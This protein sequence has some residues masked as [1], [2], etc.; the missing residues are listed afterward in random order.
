MHTC[1][2][3]DTEF[4]ESQAPSVV[5]FSLRGNDNSPENAGAMVEAPQ[6]L[7]PATH[8][9]SICGKN[10][11]NGAVSCCARGGSW[12]GKCGNPGDTRF[13]YTWDEGLRLCEGTSRKSTLVFLSVHLQRSSE[14]ESFAY[15]LIV[16]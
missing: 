16:R 6:H 15:Q 10:D 14:K 11:K 13:Q 8:N 4:R 5:S 2:P 12:F 9:C 7:N 3:L 1:T